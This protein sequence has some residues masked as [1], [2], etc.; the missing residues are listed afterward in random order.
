MPRSLRVFV[1]DGIYHVY[2]RFASG[3]RDELSAE[4]FIGRSAAVLDIDVADLASRSRQTHVV[5]ARRLIIALGRERWVQSTKDLASAL[6]SS[7]IAASALGRVQDNLWQFYSDGGQSVGSGISAFPS[8]HVGLA[9]VTLLYLW[10][11]SRILAPFGVLFATMI[12]FSSVYHGWHYAVDGYISIIAVTALWAVL[13]RRN[14][15]IAT[16]IPA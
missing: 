5:E 8:V 13:R 12:M 15:A 3:E 11:R 16:Y 1:E 10:E 14:V 6:E 4:D 9:A 2:N 7:G